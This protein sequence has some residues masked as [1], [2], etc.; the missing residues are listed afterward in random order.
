MVSSMIE[1]REFVTGG[2]SA[3]LSLLF[4][5]PEFP[6]TK[7]KLFSFSK[8]SLEYGNPTTKGTHDLFSVKT[9][10]KQAAHVSNCDTLFTAS[11]LDI[12]EYFY[13][14]HEVWYQVQY[15]LIVG[16]TFP[17]K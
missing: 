10:H 13:A 5:S 9:N 11:L 15:L 3:V 4:V 17:C 16:G 7:F 1:L 6:N 8:I 12:K 2:G 14:D